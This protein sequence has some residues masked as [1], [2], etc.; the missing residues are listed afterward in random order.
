[1]FVVVF[2]V[3]SSMLRSALSNVL[4]S[5]ALFILT[6]LLELSGGM[7]VLSGLAMP[8][9]LKFIAASFFLAFG[10]FSIH[11][12]TKA[13]LAQAGLQDLPVFFPKLLHAALSA[14][15]SIPVYLLFR[16]TLR[17]AQSFSCV[18]RADVCW[19][20]GFLAGG[21]IFLTFQ[22]IAGSILRQDRV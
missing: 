17:A 6:G 2:G 14:C 15:L 20:S 12:Q 8:Q 1:M 19:L 13:V 16:E 10:G 11:A 3:F 9:G 21:L 5:P 7:H 18:F 4:P 22:K